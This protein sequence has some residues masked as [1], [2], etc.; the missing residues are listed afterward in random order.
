MLSDFQENLT[1]LKSRLAPEQ[2]QKAQEKEF[3]FYLDIVEGAPINAE[4]LN[5][6]LGMIY[7]EG[8]IFLP[9]S[10]EGVA[11]CYVHLRTAHG[12][13]DRL[14]QAIANE[15]YFPSWR[16][17]IDNLAQSCQ[18][19]VVNNPVTRRKAKFGRYPIPPYPFHTMFA[20]FIEKIP[21]NSA[22][23]QYILVFADYL[24]KA[25]FLF[26][27]KKISSEGVVDSLKI[28]YQFTNGALRVLVTDNAS[29]FR[30]K[31]TTSFLATL[32]VYQPR[33]KAFSSYSRGLVESQ[34][35]RIQLILKKMLVN[36]SGQDAAEVI[37]LAAVLLNNVEPVA[38]KIPPM[39]LIY[40]RSDWEFGADPNMPQHTIK[41]PLLTAGL[42][43]EVKK[44]RILIQER[45]ETA[46]SELQRY[47]E[48][49][50]KKINRHRLEGSKFETGKIVFM[51]REDPAA[52]GVSRKLRARFY[53]TP[54]IIVSTDKDGNN[55]WAYVMRLVD[56]A[57]FRVSPNRLRPFVEKNRTLFDG[58][59][60]EVL[61]VLG[62][63]LTAEGL[64]ILAEKDEL[65]PIYS[66]SLSE[67]L[68]MRV[69]R[70]EARRQRRVL[71]EALLAQSE[72]EGSDVEGEASGQEDEPEAD[73]AAQDSGDGSIGRRNVR[74]AQAPDFVRYF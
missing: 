21:K 24:S 65:E 9:P 30:S 36:S 73:E 4:K 17:K 40:G 7:R 20:D 14:R 64:R 39:S 72:S 69:T 38:T 18:S 26:P 59:P 27:L 50:I 15:F 11:L 61:D 67:L 55:T 23:I 1:I 5:K 35:F 31:R 44:L 54:F 48:K 49:M 8:K 70:A 74:I 58:V 60:E 71:E 29:A 19:C 47:Q 33:T 53:K 28:L 25:I 34:N 68:P 52:A 63:P 46:K 57:V 45:V 16:E 51:T 37:F 10:L 2:I 32:N 43:E 22:R 66:D 6:K 12:G 3:Q 13:R 62:R 41:Y 56:Q 42:I